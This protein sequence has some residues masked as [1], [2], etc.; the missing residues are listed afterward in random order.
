VR[1]RRRGMNP[2]VPADRASTDSREEKSSEGL[3]AAIKDST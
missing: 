1:T 3:M 2:R